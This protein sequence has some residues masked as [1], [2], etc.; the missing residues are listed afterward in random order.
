MNGGDTSL[1]AAWTGKGMA[2]TAVT[3]LIY[4]PQ[5]GWMLGHALQAIQTRV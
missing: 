4:K 5:W 1:V 2:G 3:F